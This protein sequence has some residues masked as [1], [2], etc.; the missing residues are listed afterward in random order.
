M[1][2][3]FNTINAQ[4]TIDWDGKNTTKNVL[5]GSWYISDDG[6]FS[7]GSAGNYFLEFTSTGFTPSDVQFYVDGIIR[8]P[9]ELFFMSSGS[10][11]FD[12]EITVAEVSC[13]QTC[14]YTIKVK[15]ILG[16]EKATGSGTL[17]VV[18][19]TISGNFNVCGLNSASD[20]TLNWAGYNLYSN[21]DHTWSLSS[22]GWTMDGDNTLPIS[23]ITYPPDNTVS[24]TTPASAGSTTLTV[25]GDHL[26]ANIVKTINAVA[27]APTTPSNS[28]TN[29]RIGSTCYYKVTV[30]AVATAT[31]YLWST[32]AAFTCTSTTSSNSIS[33][34]ICGTDLLEGTTVHVYVKALNAC[35]TSISYGHKNISFPT[36]SACLE[37]TIENERNPEKFVIYYENNSWLL[38]NL[39]ETTLLHYTVYDINGKFV[40][41]ASVNS[42]SS[43]LINEMHVSGIY[44]VNIY[45]ETINENY[46]IFYSK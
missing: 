35:D 36:I 34:S 13:G 20:Y 45:G 26:C 4:F 19:E 1:T 3:I 14:N 37:K 5:K 17:L 11:S 42:N 40:S 44:L 38:Q 24:I 2:L 31:S 9:N 16:S 39:T 25:S 33:Y 18:N 7:I 32:N 12:I 10:H 28:L 43:K 27:T 6:N 30:P 29:S 21:G 46:K 8:E 23:S 41:S 15:N 22:S